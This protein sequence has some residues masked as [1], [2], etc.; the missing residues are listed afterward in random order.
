VDVI[1]TLYLALVVLH[2]VPIWIVDAMPTGDGPVH[3]YNSW[4]L[5]GL[6]TGTAPENIARA[7]EIDPRP[8]PNWLGHAVMALLIT[9]VSPIVAEKILVSLIVLVFLG[10]AWLL[11]RD[12]AIAFLAFPLTFH[13]MLMSG[14]YNFSL[15]VALFAVTLALWWRW[16][17]EP[18][19]HWIALLLLAC[20]FAHPMPAV[21]LAA[22][23]GLLWLVASRRLVHLLAFVPL[24]PFV[25]WF[26]LQRGTDSAPAER[27]IAGIAA[28]LAQCEFL[29]TFD[30]GQ[31]MIFGR[32]LFVVFAV[33]LL[34]TLVTRA[35]N[36][37]LVPLVAILAITF[38]APSEFAGGQ[39][40]TERMTLFVY[41]VAIG[42]VTT[43]WPRLLAGLL[44]VVAVANLVYQVRHFRRLDAYRTEF[45]RNTTAIAPNTT[46]LPLLFDRDT[47]GSY[48][49][50][51]TH[52]IAYTA[53]EKQL[54][55]LDNYAALTGYFPIRNRPGSF[56][57]NIPA[58]EST[59][60]TVGLAEYARRADSVFTW[61]M[62]LTAPVM[63]TLRA[64]YTLVADRGAAQVW[65]SR[66]TAS[67]AP[68]VLL[69]LAGT[70]AP[71]GAPGGARW[72]V[73]QSV[74]ND[75]S[76]TVSLMLSTC[77]APTPCSFDLA[78][79]ASMQLVA[80]SASTRF[81]LVDVVRGDPAQLRFSTVARRADVDG[82]AMHLPAVLDRDFKPRL[83]FPDLPANERLHLRFWLRGARTASLNGREI[84]VDGD[85]MYSTVLETRDVEI[86]ARGG[87]AWGFVTAGTRVILP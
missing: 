51:I 59:P 52:A 10:G 65:R 38:F 50:A 40:V 19:P 55:D 34:V 31:Q 25:A 20:W 74:R 44:T 82:I 85:G 15:G 28:Y 11:A 77:G 73:D 83:R 69:P 24:A 75:S 33:L 56:T 64:H 76:E 36:V 18:R 61:K 86:D 35:A 26:V 3:A 22:A 67:T 12:P 71:L 45:L 1:R 13:V 7:Y 57:A 4:I 47:P 46:V 42:V 70:R 2:L 27:T 37:V 30:A 58:I 5:H 43:R 79:G 17:D 80:V 63:T 16:R 66:L 54:V 23:I 9:V 32:A 14:F 48:V 53:I 78:P 41:V 49:S 72:Q 84:T 68:A 39:L 62:P 87:R 60:G 21:L 81:V 8:H 29:V 6:V